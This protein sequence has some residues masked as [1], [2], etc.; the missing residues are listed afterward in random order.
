M[1]NSLPNSSKSTFGNLVFTDDQSKALNEFNLFYN[2]VNKCP[3]FI[4]KGYAGTGKS[5][6]I[7]YIVNELLGQRKKVRLLAPT[8]KAAKVIAN[9]S[10][11][12]A[13]TIHKQVYFVG[14]QMNGSLSLV[15]AK[16]LFNPSI[17]NNQ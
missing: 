4:L 15:K 11:Q 3:A 17:F 1:D 14:N 16:N 13:Y 10:K 12:A 9:Y 7:A 8:G 6:L 5:T 2:S